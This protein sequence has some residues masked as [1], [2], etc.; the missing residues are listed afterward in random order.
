MT[1]KVTPDSPL[2]RLLI[3][4]MVVKTGQIPLYISPCITKRTVSS[5]ENH[6]SETHLR[7]ENDPN[8]AT[9]TSF[10]RALSLPLVLCARTHGNVA[11]SKIVVR[12]MICRRG[13][14]PGTAGQS[15][16]NPKGDARWFS[17]SHRTAL[18]WYFPRTNPLMPNCK[19]DGMQ[20]TR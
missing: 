6:R 10:L 20:G 3:A 14:S 4:A 12:A 5:F 9:T 8:H 7:H 17:S 15:I 13:E 19:R 16:R 1:W 2:H 11:A 18:S